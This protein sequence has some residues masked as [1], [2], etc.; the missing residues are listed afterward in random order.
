RRSPTYAYR[1]RSTIRC[2]SDD[3]SRERRVSTLGEVTFRSGR[4]C[5]TPGPTPVAQTLQ[6]VYPALLH[7]PCRGLGPGED[8]RVE[9]RHLPVAPYAGR[10]RDAVS[11]EVVRDERP[12][13]RAPIKDGRTR[14]SRVADVAEADAE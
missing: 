2:T 3:G 9:R 7:L 8:E 10:R 5:V 13:L 6:Q 4:C 14:V 12:L 1:R 11:V